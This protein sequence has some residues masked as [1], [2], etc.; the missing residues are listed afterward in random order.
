MNGNTIYL[1]RCMQLGSGTSINTVSRSLPYIC[2]SLCVRL[3]S[4][5]ISGFARGLPA[6]LT[7]FLTAAY[8]KG[9]SQ[10]P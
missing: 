7:P 9:C 1:T 5:Q 8:A 6:E 2:L 4:Y 10:A 3:H